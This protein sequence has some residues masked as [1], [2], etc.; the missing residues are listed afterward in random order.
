MVVTAVS[1]LNG[2][3]PEPMRVIAPLAAKMLC[4]PIST[5]SWLEPEPVRVT[6]PVPVASTVKGLEALQQKIMP[7]L[8]V[9]LVPVPVIEILPFAVFNELVAVPVL[10]HMPK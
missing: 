2:P 5:K 4:A 6:E 1:V 8:F 3:A 10:L 9:A 7:R